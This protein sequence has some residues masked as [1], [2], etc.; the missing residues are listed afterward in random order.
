MTVSQKIQLFLLA[1][2]IL[3]V[4][5]FALIGSFMTLLVPFTHGTRDGALMLI[6]I[7]V[8]LL[9][10]PTLALC[11][12]ALCIYKTPRVIAKNRNLAWATLISGATGEAALL[13]GAI[14]NSKF[15][16]IRNDYIGL[17]FLAPALL[18]VYNLLIL[19]SAMMR[20]DAFGESQSRR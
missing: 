1:P 7:Y 15:D 20:P 17:L 18:G 9:L 2:T 8:G 10:V 12:L 5:P 14:T 16:S 3:T 19:A 13:F 6:P 11:L 4:G